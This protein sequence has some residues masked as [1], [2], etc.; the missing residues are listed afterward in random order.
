MRN[1][2]CGVRSA[3]LFAVSAMLANTP[4]TAQGAGSVAGTQRSSNVHIVSHIPMRGV[5]DIEIEQELSRPYAYIST[6]LGFVV[7]DLKI[8][9]KARELYRWKIDNPELHQGSS[10]APTYLK[11]R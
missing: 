11:S 8:P 9:E 3:T 1:A 7:V 10:L 5:A 2:E 6:D 4:A